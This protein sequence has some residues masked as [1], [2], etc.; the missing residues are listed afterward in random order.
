MKKILFC[1]MAIVAAIAVSSCAT[2]ERRVEDVAAKIEKGETLDDEDYTTMIE[3]VGEYA[4]K[5]Q[6]Y[7]V[8]DT[9]AQYEAEKNALKE[10]YPYVDLFRDCIAKTPDLQM[11]EENMNLINKYSDYIMFTAPEGTTIQTD[12]EAAGVEVAAPETDNGVIAGA[13]DEVKETEKGW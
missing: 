13:V 5:M 9:D 6:P 8:N 12:P 11:S 7:V 2:S 4:E 3:Y 1:M 10:K